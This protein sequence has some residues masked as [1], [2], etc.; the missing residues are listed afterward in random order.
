MHERT[1]STNNRRVRALQSPVS[2]LPTTQVYVL[3]LHGACHRRMLAKQSE[4]NMNLVCCPPPAAPA[5][6]TSALLILDTYVRVARA[7]SVSHGVFIATG[8]QDRK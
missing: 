4:T 5:L 3:E 7:Q 2:M 8:E 6:R 1:S